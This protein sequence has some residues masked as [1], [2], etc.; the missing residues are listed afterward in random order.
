[1]KKTETFKTAEELQNLGKFGWEFLYGAS[2]IVKE[3]IDD[4]KEN[5]QLEV[6]FQYKEKY[7]IFFSL[8]YDIKNNKLKQIAK[9]DNFDALNIQEIIEISLVID[10]ARKLLFSY[11]PIRLQSLYNTVEEINE[12]FDRSNTFIKLENREK[13]NSVSRQQ[14]LDLQK[15]IQACIQSEF[16]N[17]KNTDDYYLERYR[18]VN[19][20][21]H[22]IISY[23]KFFDIFDIKELKELNIP[24]IEIVV[25]KNWHDYMPSE[26]TFKKIVDCIGKYVLRA[27]N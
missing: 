5:V 22:E 24:T 14:L 26:E 16:E 12:H 17:M 15:E 8:D 27:S 6:A 21:I 4:I 20:N 7:K 9:C 2:R 10:D 3:G 25:K 18:F 19:E 11:E 1:M 23:L 13:L